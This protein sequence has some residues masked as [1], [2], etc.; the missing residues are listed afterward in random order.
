M[1]S[2]TVRALIA[3]ACITVL[4]GI[5]CIIC[6]V[7]GA[8]LICSQSC[9]AQCQGRPNYATP[10]VDENN[11][12]VCQECTFRKV[13][14]TDPGTC[15]TKYIS[16]QETAIR[17]VLNSIGA[18][19]LAVGL[20]MGICLIATTRRNIN[21]ESTN[22]L[23][24]V[25]C[26]VLFVSGAAVIAITR[27]SGV[28]MC[29]DICDELSCGGTRFPDFAQAWVNATSGR[30]RCQHCTP[31]PN[32]TTDC[33]AKDITVQIATVAS[34]TYPFACMFVLFACILLIISLVNSSKPKKPRSTVQMAF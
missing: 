21:V 30:T 26:L 17:N 28:N 11:L 10:G 15:E 31:A 7:S 18:L 1:A 6:G 27:S 23:L 20:V 4:F 5:A 16:N 33:I 13:S 25:F 22:A 12:L 19:L 2:P 14:L 3:I 9:D 32:S 8:S 34:V 29:D 24:L